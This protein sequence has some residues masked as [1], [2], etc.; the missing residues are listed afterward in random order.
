MLNNPSREEM[1]QR[2]RELESELSHRRQTRPPQGDAEWIYRR[3]LESISDA[4]IVTDEFGKIGYVCPNTAQVL[5]LSQAEIDDQ[6]NIQGLLSGIQFEFPMPPEQE[7]SLNLECALTTADGLERCLLVNIK[8]IDIDGGSLMYVI[9][10]NTRQKR[11]FE[12]LEIYKN[13]INLM[14]D[15][16][17]FLDKDNRYVIVNDA[18]EQFADVPKEKLIGLSMAEHLGQKVFNA[19]VTPHFD[20][21]MQGETVNHR[22]WIDYPALGRRYMDVTYSPYRSGEG[23]ATGVIATTRDITTEARAETKYR[24]LVELAQE[25]IWVINETDQTRFA[26]A[27]MAKML[28]YTPE[29]M[30]GQSLFDFMDEQGRTIANRNIER[31]KQGIKEQHDFEFITKGGDRIYTT[32]ETAPIMDVDGNYKGAIAG[33]IDITQRRKALRG[34]EKSREKFKALFENSPDI[35]ALTD[36]SGTFLEIN[37]VIPGFEKSDVIGTKVI[38]YLTAGDQRAYHQAVD[39]AVETGRPQSYSVQIKTPEGQDTHWHNR[40]SPLISG[41]SVERLVINFT[42]IT[43]QKRMEDAYI[44]SEA[45]LKSL[46]GNIPDLVWLKDAD[47]VYLS[48]NPSFER[49]FG[50]KEA[51]IIGKTDYDFVENELADFFREHDDKAMAAGRP[52]L[53]EEELTFAAD[54]YQGLFETIK[55]PICDAAGNFIGVLGIARDITERENAKREIKKRQTELHNLLQT[56]QCGIVVHAADTA[57][58][59]LNPA[60]CKLLGMRRE[61]LIGVR[62]DDHNWNLITESGKPLVAHNYPVNIVKRTGA[63]LT[64]YVLGLVRPDRQDP[65]WLLVNAAPEFGEDGVLHQIIVSSADISELKKTQSLLEQKRRE[66][67]QAHKM[68]SIGSLAGGI[69]HDFNNILSSIIGF[70]ELALEEVGAGSSLEDSLGEVFAAGKRAQELVQQILTFARQSDEKRKPVQVDTIVAEVLRFMRSSLPATIEI[71]HQVDSN[72]VIIGNPTQVHQMLMNLCTNAAHAMEAKGGTLFV[73]LKKNVPV[74]NLGLKAGSYLEI[75]ITDNG[76]GIPREILDSIFDP[77]FTTKPKGRG[78]GMGLA[79]VHGIVKSYGGKILVDSVVGSG[80][81]VTLYLPMTQRAKQEQVDGSELLPR[82]SEHI[83]LVDDEAPILKMGN[84][85]LTGLGYTVTTRSSGLEAMELFKAK[86]ET[87]DLVITDMTMPNLTGDVLA[88]ELLKIRAHIP[89]ILCTG[90]SNRI[91]ERVAVEMG[92]RDL[93]YKP[94]VK[95]DLAKIVRRV[96]DD[97]QG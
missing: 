91:S 49:L 8:T 55:T 77:Y 18:Y 15:G 58:V 67:V 16:V 93:I 78:T 25:G 43:T 66:L 85:M 95:A 54:G 84:Q 35:V 17:C 94:I 48:C 46:V 82:G 97:A 59:D 76:E 79:V 56:V 21:C 41:D 69:A 72:A 40:I 88:A 45:R 5:G 70:T 83:L 81:A 38:D 53:N 10:D 86:P 27:S 65:V 34:L 73:G 29:E 30:V 92:I 50:T 51:E 6:E 20:K 37:R 1:A 7:E 36:L 22:Q 47:G 31:R 44:K 87:F 75:I 62:A 68:E 96:L 14:Q 64:D 80:T 26:N 32:I 33:I 3:I 60:A 9:H 63:P 90:Y 23:K 24:E 2:I 89:I 61:D 39:A 52:S 71:Q 57:I 28:G 12:Q 74:D 19:S 42:D 4:V 13:I 11:K